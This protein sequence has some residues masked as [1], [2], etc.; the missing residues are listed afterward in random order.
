M[1]ICKT[2]E[3]GITI[4][5]LI[6]TIVLLLILS[7]I[8]VNSGKDVIEQSNFSKFGAELK[9]M[10]TNINN[11]Y[12]KYKSGESLNSLTGDEILTS[13]GKDITTN[14][15]ISERAN[16]AFKTIEEGGSGITDIAGYRFWDTETIQSLKLEGIENQY[17]VNIAKRSVISYI[18]F[19]YE[20]KTYYTVEQLP[21]GLYNVEYKE[22]I[23][24]E[25]T[26][27]VSVEKISIDKWKIKVSNIQYE[28]YNTKWKVKYKI[29]TEDTW[30]TSEDLE[31]VVNK[32][33]NYKIKVEKE[34]I[35]SAEKEVKV[36]E[37]L[38]LTTETKPYYP[39]KEFEQVAGTNLDNGLVV[40]DGTNYWT[41]VE[42]PITEEIYTTATLNLVPN[43]EGIYTEAECQM[44]ESDL[45]DYTTTL[46]S[47]SDNKTSRMGYKDEWFDGCGIASAEEYDLL[48]RKMLS[49]VYT[50]GGFWIGQYEM[51]SSTYTFIAD[52]GARTPICQKGAYVY[53]Y[54]KA[55]EAQV[56]A[57]SINSGDRTSSLLFGIQWD[58]ILKHLQNKGVSESLL[59]SNSLT[60]GNYKN[61]EFVIDNGKYA[62]KDGNTWVGYKDYTEIVENIEYYSLLDGI[63]PSG[64]EILLTT[65]ASITNSKMNIYDLAG[66]VGEFT[67][68]HSD[69]V[70]ENTYRGGACTVNNYFVQASL[71]YYYPTTSLT[72]YIG[73]RPTIY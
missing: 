60:W 36:R 7:S 39:G 42:V 12:D 21:G 6:I 58:L 13:I 29:G 47:G 34:N 67:L 15:E 11:I 68:E 19:E 66:N 62:Y 20:N 14:S 3:K 49:S 22:T 1:E 48:K 37:E 35:V 57:T 54:I 4:V 26:F 18:G 44:I 55:R 33:G 73:F 63:K 24:N 71:R 52:N 38:E 27:D 10:Q 9:I 50:N 61:S 2:N 40:T 46:L 25:P 32:I 70:H 43:E 51:G 56:L 5:S 53:N 59:I 41:W 31:F 30:N 72:Y 65:G 64:K 23:S 69:N 16:K 8:V 28:G 45:E 17:F